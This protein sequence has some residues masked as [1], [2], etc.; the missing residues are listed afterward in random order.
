MAAE[1]EYPADKDD[2]TDIL[3]YLKPQISYKSHELLLLGKHTFS[4]YLTL[5][6]VRPILL[7]I[8]HSTVE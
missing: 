1:L 4:K 3:L 6:L 2:C 7:E 8:F 5:C